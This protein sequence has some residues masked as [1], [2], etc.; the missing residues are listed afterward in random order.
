MAVPIAVASNAMKTVSMILSQVTLAVSVNVGLPTLISH[1]GMDLLGFSNGLSV[2]E[3]RPPARNIPLDL[4][5][6]F[7]SVFFTPL[8]V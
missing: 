1:G 2:L 5:L 6:K 3:V 4:A 8:V 7:P